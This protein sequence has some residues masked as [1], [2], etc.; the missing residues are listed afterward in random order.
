MV[1]INYTKYNKGERENKYR[2]IVNLYGEIKKIVLSQDNPYLKQQ[3]VR[4]DYNIP[5]EY[6]KL[7]YYENGYKV[8]NNKDDKTIYLLINREHQQVKIDNIINVNQVPKLLAV[9][10]TYENK[11]RKIL[12]ELISSHTNAYLTSYEIP[13]EI[14][15]P[16]DDGKKRKLEK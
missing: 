11:E 14:I 1:E 2:E 10:Y 5:D 3:Y 7:Y 12:W 4:G 13:M 16:K 15:T 6:R 9:I 8:I